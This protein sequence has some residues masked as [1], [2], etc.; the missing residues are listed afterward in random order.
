MGRGEN[1]DNTEL[2]TRLAA[3]VEE[4]EKKVQTLEDIEA[5][6]RLQRAYGYYLDKMMWDELVDCFAED[7]SLELAQRGVYIG[8]KNIRK[9]MDLMPDGQN[10]IQYGLLMNHMN[11]Q[12]I[13]T[14]D[15]GGKTAKGR[16]RMFAQ[17]GKWKEKAFWAEG[18]YENTYVK[19]DGIWKA[20][21]MHVYTTFMTPYDK[22][23]GKEYENFIPKPDPNCPP[24]LPPTE[25]YGDYPDVYIPPFHYVHPVTGKKVDTR[26]KERTK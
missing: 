24:D 21:S 12:G 5:I 25:V 19:E 23:W 16:W 20:K 3:K 15:P 2:I 17:V 6:K 9:L 1:M 22:G 26:I 18:T 7:G 14:I 10:G 8:K 4:L 11:L 13:V